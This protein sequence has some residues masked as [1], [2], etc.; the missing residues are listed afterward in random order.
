[1][2]KM[3]AETIA[4]EFKGKIT[5]CGGIDVQ[6]FIVNN[7]PKQIEKGIQRLT[8]IF[9]GPEGGFIIAPANSIMPETPLEKV[10][11]MAHAMRKYGVRHLGG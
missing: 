3:D 10:Q 9:D 4:A 2:P 1:M 7:T 11:A 8:E 5:F 6:Y